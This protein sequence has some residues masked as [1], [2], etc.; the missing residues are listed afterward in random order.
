[1]SIDLTPATQ[2]LADLVGAVDDDDLGRP[3][4]CPQYTVADLLDHIHGLAVAFA[5]VA[6]KESGPETQGAPG[7]AAHLDGDWRSSIPTA[8]ADLA[9]AWNQPG[10]DEGMTEAGGMEMPGEVARAVAVAEV[11][12]HG[13]DLARAIG[14]PFSAADHELQAVAGFYGE[15][16]DEA[17]ST[18]PDAAF[19][20]VADV[21][22]A[23]PLLDRALA[24][25]GRAPDWSP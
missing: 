19:G 17:R 15:F 25:S 22:D 1:M 16:P 14:R 13:W 3:T 24:L 23:A 18:E 11:V 21:G 10:A 12:V 4:P 9:A 20:P 8:L 5:M 7:D 2:R 6:R